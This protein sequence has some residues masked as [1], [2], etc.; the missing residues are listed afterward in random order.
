MVQG[1]E[2]FDCAVE[3]E[4]GPETN[5][6][7]QTQVPVHFLGIEPCG[8]FV[9]VRS[10]AIH[11]RKSAFENVW[12]A[13]CAVS[14]ALP[15]VPSVRALSVDGSDSHLEEAEADVFG[16][17][18]LDRLVGLEPVLPERPHPQLPIGWCHQITQ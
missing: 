12:S 17:V 14:L 7:S 9:E 13:V 8:G 4:R 6:S 15:E 1:V 11:P 5:A 16:L 2:L 3:V 18:L 10:E